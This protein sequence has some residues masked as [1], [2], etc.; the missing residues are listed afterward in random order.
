MFHINA[1]NNGTGAP[2]HSTGTSNASSLIATTGPAI[3]AAAIV[4][5]GSPATN[6]SAAHSASQNKFATL[7]LNKAFASVASKTKSGGPSGS[8]G[9]LW[10]HFYELDFSPC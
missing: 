5:S 4:A 9:M 10:E 1:A 3:T 7:N 2:S 6:P 8:S